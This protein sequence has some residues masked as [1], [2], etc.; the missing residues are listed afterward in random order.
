MSKETP[1]YFRDRSKLRAWLQKHHD[2]SAEQW[3]GYFKKGSGRPSITWPESVEEALCFGWIDGVRKTVDEERYKIRFTPRRPG[4]HWSAKNLESMNRL[5]AD[6]LVRDAGRAVYEARKPDN[7]S[8]AAHEQTGRVAL[9]RG[10]GAALKANG[11]AWAYW[12]AAT[13][14]YRKQVTWWIVSAKKL[15]TKRRRLETLI[16]SSSKGEVIPSM[17]WMKKR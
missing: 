10:F 6:G 3:V 7:E 17:R 4:S 16:Q 13:P 14:S 9:P 12:Q 2:R 15:E 5:L 8:R 1:K 11:E